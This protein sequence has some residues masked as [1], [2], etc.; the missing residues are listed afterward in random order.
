LVDLN[1]L[2]NL[3]EA[4]LY[5][6]Q[7]N[8]TIEEGKKIVEI[9]PTFANVHIHMSQAY[10][11]SGKYDLWLDEWEKTATLNDDPEDLALVRAVRKE[12]S[13]SGFHAAMTRLAELQQEQS[14]RFYIDPAFIAAD[15][16]IIGD[17]DQAFAWLEKAYAEKSVFIEYIKAVPHYDS[18]R[19]DP[20]YT[21]LSK[22][23]GL[24]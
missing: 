22:R 6:R 8:R 11:Y 15:Y 18:L 12:Y 10:L 23:M 4:Y 3:A 24:S 1:G 9:D 14:K 13:K 21:D 2:D 16:A 5:T 7:Y 20:R 19:S 17:K